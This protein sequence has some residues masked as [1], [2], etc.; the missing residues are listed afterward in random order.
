MSITMN[1]QGRKMCRRGGE[2]V[3][4]YVRS[5][6]CHTQVMVSYLCRGGV[7]WCS[8]HCAISHGPASCIHTCTYL[9]ICVAVCGMY[10]RMYV[11]YVCTTTSSVHCLYGVS[12]QSDKTTFFS[13]TL[14]CH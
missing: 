4:M 14:D 11:P 2:C 13:C 7:V 8:V 6:V 1:Q 5:F 10:V 9:H 3:V 12:H